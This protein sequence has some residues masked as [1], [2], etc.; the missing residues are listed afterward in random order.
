MKNLFCRL[1]QIIRDRRHAVRLHDAVTRDRQIRT[2]G[3]DERDV[4]SVQRR[5]HRQVAFRFERFAREDG[6]DRMRDRVVNVQQIQV[7]GLRNCRHLGRERESV[8]LMLKQRI[9]HHLDFMKTHALVQ[10]GEPR[11]Q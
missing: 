11:R 3:A 2:I 6:A 8:R 7:L 1:L 9:R 10:F 5:D 4:C